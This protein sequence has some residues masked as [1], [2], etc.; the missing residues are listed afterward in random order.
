MPRPAGSQK[1]GGRQKGTPNIRSQ[2]S[3]KAACDEVGVN[4]FVI[5]AQ[6]AKSGSTE[7]I[8]GRNAANL[9]DYLVP[10]LLRTEHTGIDGGALDGKLTVEIIYGGDSDKEP[11]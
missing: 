7:E 11:D 1:T 8:R 6:L 3:V 10:K 2:F 4:P 5:M 9:G